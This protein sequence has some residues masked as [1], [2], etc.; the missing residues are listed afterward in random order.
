VTGRL[1]ISWITDDLA[2]GGSFPPAA[3]E[4]LAREL[5]VRAVIDLR[6]E[7]CDDAQILRR[8]GIELL[9]LPTEDHCAV[10]PEMLA[11]GV[12]FAERQRTAGGG[13]LIH[14]E[15]GIGRSATLALCVLVGR[16]FAPLEALAL[17][18]TRRALVSPSPAQYE[19]WIA[20]L[21]AFRRGR[22][23]GWDIP[24]FDAFAAI[25]YSHLTKAG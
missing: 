15:H 14:C 16:G 5:R 8:H 17:A 3:A 4:A 9:H 25:A 23:C 6:L 11:A 2:I 12:A 7:A 19:G 10:A 21:D 18:K 20:W 24:P 1:N 13:V 22:G